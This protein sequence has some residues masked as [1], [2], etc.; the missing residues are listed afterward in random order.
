MRPVS[1]IR[2]DLSAAL[3]DG[4]GTTRDLARRTGWA[5]GVTREALNNMV[6]SGAARK[7]HSVRVKGVK[8]P[9]PVYARPLPPPDAD[10]ADL[11]SLISAWVH[12]PLAACEGA[13]I[14]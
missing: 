5:I 3:V 12:G 10:G 2:L 4:P 8:R 14:R 6:R 9:V 1:E 13:A 11:Q 7:P